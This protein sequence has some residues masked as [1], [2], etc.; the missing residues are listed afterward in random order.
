[1]G[2]AAVRTKVGLPAH[3]FHATAPLHCLLMLSGADG[4][5][6]G[7]AGLYTALRRRLAAST[8][9]RVLTVQ[10]AYRRPAHMPDALADV[11]ATLQRVRDRY[12]VHSVVLMGWSFGGAVAVA[13][14]G[15]D[16]HTHP[17]TQ[18]GAVVGL[19]TL[20]AQTDGT[21]CIRRL[22]ESRLSCLF[23]HG[24]ADAVLPD[25]C[26]HELYGRYGGADKELRVYEGDDHACSGS[27][28][29]VLEKVDAWLHRVFA[30][31]QAADELERQM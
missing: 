5:L 8:R 27:M 11:A 30:E 2:A 13:A 21:A 9:L 19:V 23:L 31:R 1:M 4:R 15:E 16:A 18:S 28:Q 24:G 7:P 6:R 29:A 22:H 14:A 26:S 10:M 25:A 17:H 3:S 12:G 20:G